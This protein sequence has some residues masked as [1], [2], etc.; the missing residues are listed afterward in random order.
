MEKRAGPVRPTMAGV[1]TMMTARETWIY[2][3]KWDDIT[4]AS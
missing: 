3:K 4:L 2:L 1:S